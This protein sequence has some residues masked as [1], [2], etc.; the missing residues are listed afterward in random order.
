M[1]SE[2]RHP[3]IE[4]YFRSEIQY[5]YATGWGTLQTNRK[6][7][8]FANKPKIGFFGVR[9]SQQIHKENKRTVQFGIVFTILVF[10]R[11]T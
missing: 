11:V 6:S 9:R 3:R 10:G 1:K 8:I 5:E 2:T 7:G 4:K